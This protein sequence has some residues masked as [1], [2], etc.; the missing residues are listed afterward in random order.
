MSS[1]LITS[2][3][4]NFRTIDGLKVRYADRGTAREHL[5]ADESLAREHLRVRTDVGEPR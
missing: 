1:S 5:A 3:A 2:I 4:P